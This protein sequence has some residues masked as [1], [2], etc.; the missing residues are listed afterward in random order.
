MNKQVS[1]IAYEAPRNGED[2]ELSD[3]Q[4][5][6]SAKGVRGMLATNKTGKT[7]GQLLLK[8]IRCGQLS[9]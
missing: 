5:Q 6:Y 4:S 1:C 3:I 9:V 8:R 2:V 7:C